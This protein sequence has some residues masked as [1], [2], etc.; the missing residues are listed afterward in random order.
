M[1]AWGMLGAGIAG[2][3][4]GVGTIVVYDISAPLE[5]VQWPSPVRFS[6][7]GINVTRVA[8][9]ARG[10][11][12]PPPKNLDSDE[13]F[14]PKHILF[15][16]KLR[17]VAIY[18]LLGDIWAKKCLFESKTVFLGQKC[19]ITWYILHILLSKICKFVITR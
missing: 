6:T 4:M 16:C 2:V 18:A 7:S 5:S 15:C 14:K 3:G 8:E 10:D 11:G 12:G 19:T 13:N 17:F 9:A 1:G